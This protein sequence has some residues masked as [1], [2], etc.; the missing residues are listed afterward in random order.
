MLKNLKISTKISLGYGIIIGLVIVLVLVTIAKISSSNDITNKVLKLRV[1][2]TLSSM[3]MINGMNHSLA[4]LRGWIILG[5]DKFKDERSIAWSK[6]IE[7][8]LDKMTKFSKSWTNPENIER[9]RKITL[10]LKDF[11]KYQVQIEDIAHDMNNQPALKVLFN[12]AAPQANILIAN[13]TKII[14]IELKL[15]ATP[16]RK[17]L[18]GMMADVRGTTGLGLANIRAYLLSGD[19][20]FKKLFDKF[21]AKN[22]KRFADL[23]ANSYLLT[24]EQ[25]KAFKEFSKAREIFSP[26]P[27]KMFSIRSSDSWNLANKW[28]GTKAAPSAF[29]I[30]KELDAMISNQK[31]LMQNDM[32]ASQHSIDSLIKFEWILLAITIIISLTIAVFIRKT[33]IS[34]L[35]SFQ[36]G[37]L[38]FFMYLNKEQSNITELD[39]STNDEFGLMSKV[40]NQNIAKT[41]DLMDQDQKVIDAV[42]DSVETAKTG[43]MNQK[44]EVVTSNEGLEELK[45][46]FNELL[47]VVSNKV[48]ND[49]N[50]ISE[51]LNHYQKLDFTHRI[52]NDEGE[53]S[54]GLN[55]FADIIN[56]MLVE[57]KSN[58][59]TLENSSDILLSNVD[60]LN[61]SSNTAAASL[62][63]TAAAIEEITANIE[64]NTNTVMEMANY[65]NNVKDSVSKGQLLANKTTSSMDEINT[66]V[67]SISEAIVIIDQIAFQTNILSLNAAVEAATAGEAGKGFAVV[68][69]EVRNLASKSAEAASEIK[70][71]VQNATVKANSGKKISDEMI[72][73]Y[74]NL[75]ESITKTLELIAN[76]EMASKEQSLAISQINDTVNQLDQQTQKNANVAS[77]TKD[78]ALQTQNI[79]HTIVNNANEKE[80]IGKDSVKAKESTVVSLSTSVHSKPQKTIKANNTN[81]KVTSS[82]DSDDEWSSF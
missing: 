35:V 4:A 29:K 18:L 22:I 17:A 79:S 25:T 20:K 1:P 76:V 51:A 15:E 24:S 77:E 72:D 19:E 54:I 68:A 44:I 55:N 43:L 40:V 53:V 5:K 59:M 9:L 27:P 10:Y 12:D 50:K 60:I 34:S 42:K 7:P 31:R 6:E 58:G 39:E 65:G 38:S 13:I 80:F 32:I 45:D 21:W 2:T 81:P 8:A 82:N 62:E 28:L 14:D 3:E 66:E 33:I 67:T 78:I 57:N 75:N 74:T 23:T 56:K 64:H 11:K 70:L 63:E 16:E 26:L 37:L 69:Q 73:G 36:N 61:T 49:L 46:G 41:K 30:K 52:K 48:S 71:L 47:S